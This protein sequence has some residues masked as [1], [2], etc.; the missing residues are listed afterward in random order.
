MISN[1]FKDYI[2]YFCFNYGTTKPIYKTILCD[3]E[4][5]II[6]KLIEMNIIY[7]SEIV[8]DTKTNIVYY[9]RYDCNELREK[10]LI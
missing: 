8:K 2:K 10:E 3:S 6:D 7:K 1:S 4:I 9:L 5:E